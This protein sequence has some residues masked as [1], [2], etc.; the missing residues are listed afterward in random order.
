MDRT[1]S[2]VAS[3]I[4]VIKRK[5]PKESAYFGPFYDAM[6][7]EEHDT[8]TFVDPGQDLDL[9]Y[10]DNGTVVTR[11]PRKTDRRTRVWYGPIGS[12]DKLMKNAQLRDK[13][14]ANHNILGLEMEAAGTMNVL[15]VGVIRGVCDYA[16]P[17]K[18][19]QWQPYAAAM[20][21]AY[22][23]AILEKVP[24]P[25]R[26]DKIEEKS[27]VQAPSHIDVVA[28]DIDKIEE[29]SGSGS[30]RPPAQNYVNGTNQGAMMGNVNGGNFYF[31]P[32]A[33][34]SA[35]PQVAQDQVHLEV[36]EDRLWSSVSRETYASTRIFSSSDWIFRQDAFKSWQAPHSN[37]VDNG[38]PTLLTIKGKAFTGK[39]SIMRTAVE[40]SL[41]EKSVITLYHFFGGVSSDP[42][43]ELLRDLLGQLLSALPQDQKPLDDIKR[44]SGEIKKGRCIDFLSHDRLQEDFKRILLAV[45]PRLT[46]RIFVDAIDDCFGDYTSHATH[47]SDEDKRRPL[48]LLKVLANILDS[49]DAA[50]MDLGI[51]VSRRPQPEFPGAEPPA[52]TIS[53]VHYMDEVIKPF[54]QEKLECIPDPARVLNLLLKMSE[55]GA[56]NFR[57]ATA[58]CEEI[59]IYKDTVFEKLEEIASRV[60][61]DHEA[62]YCRAIRSS[63]AS[64]PHDHD[65][66]LRFL[67]VALGAF[68]PLTPEEFRHVYAAV[69]VTRFGDFNI[70]KWETSDSGIGAAHF[71]AFLSTTTGGLLEIV[72]R[73]RRPRYTVKDPAFADAYTI[74]HHVLFQQRSTESFLRSDKGLQELSFTS[75]SH[76]DLDCHRLLYRACGS[77]LDKCHLRGEEDTV[78]VDYACRYWLRHSRMCGERLPDSLPG[79]MRRCAHPKAKI[80][81]QKQIL[82]L[83]MDLEFAF[84]E[85]QTSM[86]MLL[87][88]LGCTTLLQKHLDT[89]RECG[90]A[91]PD[92]SQ[93]EPPSEIFMKSLRSAIK[94]R[95]PDTAIYLLTFLP[96]KQMNEWGEECQTLLYMACSAHDVM[97]DDKR[98]LELI[99]KLLDCGAAPTAHSDAEHELPLHFAIATANE[100]LIRM[101]SQGY[102]QQDPDNFVAI[103]ENI[104][105]ATSWPALH[106]A[107]KC[108]CLEPEQRIAV[109]NVLSEVVPTGAD[110]LTLED[111]D[112]RT[113]VDLAEETDDYTIIDKVCEFYD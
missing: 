68:R 85:S 75:P 104:H 112:K 81:I 76:L 13:L 73:K 57:W 106:Y 93:E 86:M 17:D 52:T 9:F 43:A 48:Q 28:T 33:D 15:P 108:G 113:A 87:A 91:V 70:A 31:G 7:D 23:K 74:E 37:E 27:P 107:L 54:I 84:L 102:Q 2:K 80:F 88:T 92:P 19:K 21:A 103:F 25:K 1:A 44:W 29:A 65:R 64:S 14:R 55:T 56:H 8:G 105:H 101:L 6:K 72:S 45:K 110:L 97:R 66:M 39:S 49:A 36:C 20:A 18:N 90:S 71:E 5:A 98:S 94:S 24:L 111:R 82:K 53:L 89:C 11:A 26:E 63:K 50:K 40:A 30:T 34:V 109:L 96:S 46:F 42:T 95:K 58:V 79:F 12:G 16:D 77:V 99:E 38:S 32:Q 4:G 83:H 3:A 62:V 78:M 41:K 100:A 61:E 35:L 60:I 51:C 69:S 10:D 22:A 59:M 47:Y 67:L